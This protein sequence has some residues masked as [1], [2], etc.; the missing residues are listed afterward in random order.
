MLLLT[1]YRLSHDDANSLQTAQ[2]LQSRVLSFVSKTKESPTNSHFEI[3][4]L[5][6]A[7]SLFGTIF[8]S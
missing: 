5:L 3:S 2:A 8:G 4:G 7:L 6:P 1:G